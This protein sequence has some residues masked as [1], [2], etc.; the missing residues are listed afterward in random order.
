MPVPVRVLIYPPVVP[1]PREIQFPY[2]LEPEHIELLDDVREVS[3]RRHLLKDLMHPELDR[4][5]WL[6]VRRYT[7]GYVLCHWPRSYIDGQHRVYSDVSD[8]HRRRQDYIA[9]RG[10]EFG[11]SVDKE[12]AVRRGVRTISDVIV[13]GAITMTAEIDCRD[14]TLAEALKKAKI[15]NDTTVPLWLTDRKD[16]AY[17]FRVPYAITNERRGTHPEAWTVATGPRIL[18]YERCR[19][20]ICPNRRQQCTERHLIWVPRGLV[21]PVSVDDIVREIPAG[22]LKPINVSIG[23]KP[24]IYLATPSDCERWLSENPLTAPAA[25]QTPIRNEGPRV[26]HRDDYTSPAPSPVVPSRAGSEVLCARCGRF[27]YAVADW[28]CMSCRWTLGL[29]AR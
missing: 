11:Y 3:D 2:P 27:R 16:P 17:A 8:E 6:Y 25:K 5:I 13:R 29:D 14:E 9:D 21:A 4:D 26:W 23:G 10:Q 12:R 18:R 15:S 1:E 7:N 24:R 28:L 20:E 22:Q 19:P